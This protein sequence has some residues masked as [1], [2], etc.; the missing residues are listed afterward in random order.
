MQWCRVTENSSD[1]FYPCVDTDH[2]PFPVVLPVDPGGRPYS[3]PSCCFSDRI[4]LGWKM[5]LPLLL[6][7]SVSQSEYG[8]K[9]PIPCLLFFFF[10][11]LIAEF[12]RASSL[13]VQPHRRG[14][15]GAGLYGAHAIRIRSP[16]SGRADLD[17]STGRRFFS[18]DWSTGFWRGYRAGRWLGPARDGE[19]TADQ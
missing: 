13:A 15:T 8:S 1:P 14:W 19:I 11:V 2:R 16:L 17:C 3:S 4:Q 9:L 12:V 18:V 7:P 10:L 5:I 6:E